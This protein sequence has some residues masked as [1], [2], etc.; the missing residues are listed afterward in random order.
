MKDGRPFAFAGLWESWDR[1][2]GGE[3]QSC[4]IL[5]TDA[6]DL[7]SEIHHRM[8]VILPQEDYE[9]WLDSTLREPDQLL[10]LLAPYPTNGMEAYPVSRRVNNPSN[11]EPG[12][13]ESV[14]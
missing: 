10:P 5:T 9:L 12:C 6:N 4:T 14:A 3:I 13:V 2:G 1:H 7:V 8:P 11:N